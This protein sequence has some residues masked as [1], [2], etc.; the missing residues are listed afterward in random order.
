MIEERPKSN[1]ARTQDSLTTQHLRQ[2]VAQEAM[3]FLTTAHL[4]QALRAAA[5]E[6]P[7][8]Q[9]APTNLPGETIPASSTETENK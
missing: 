8:G 2:A 5:A 7:G 6:E 3:E 4:K 9:T 1:R